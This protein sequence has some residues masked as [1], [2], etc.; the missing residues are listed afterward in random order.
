MKFSDILTEASAAKTFNLDTSA[1]FDIWATL[2]DTVEKCYPN[3]EE[4]VSHM[5]LVVNSMYRVSTSE[6]K[7][8]LDHVI[9]QFY[10]KKSNLDD[11][12][13]EMFAKFKKH[14]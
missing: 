4:V 9:H 10:D 14:R 6:I 12:I 8:I 11:Y 2:Q 1:M 7:P 3:K 13:D 5:N